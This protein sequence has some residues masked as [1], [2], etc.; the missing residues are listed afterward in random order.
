VTSQEF[1]SKKKMHQREKAAHC[2]HYLSPHVDFLALYTV[3]SIHDFDAEASKVGFFSY[4]KVQDFTNRIF[5]FT[6]IFPHIAWKI[7]A[8]LRISSSV[9]LALFLFDCE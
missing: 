9:Q 1:T 3:S 7:N 8:D 5:L 4:L 2:L 6:F